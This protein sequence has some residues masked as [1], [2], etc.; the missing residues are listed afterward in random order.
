MVLKILN[1]L[2]IILEVLVIF[3]LLIIVHELGHF[4][5]AKW[6]GLVIEKFGIWFGKPIWKKTIGGVE[7]SL[8]SIPAGGFVALPQMAP[9]EVMEGKT[10][11]PREQLP[12]ASALDKIIVAFAGPLFS[13]GLAVLFAVIVWKAGR[14][15]SEAENTQVVGYVA[16]QSPAAEAGVLRGDKILSVDGFPVSRFSGLG[17]DSIIWRIVRSEGESIALRVEREKK[18]LTLLPKPRVPGKANWWNRKGL[19]QI[20]IGPAISS[21]VADVKLDS[22]AGQ[23]GLQIK[24]IITAVN[25]EKIY[26]PSDI[27]DYAAAHPDE[28][29][30]LTVQRGGSD[31]RLPFNPR[32]VK[33]NGVAKGSPAE[34]GGLKAGDII[35]GL[36]GKNFPVAEA[37]INY[38]S[39]KNNV[40]VKVQIQRGKTTEE[41]TVTPQVPTISP[42]SQKKPK[43]GAELAD[44]DGV[45]F[46]A[47]GKYDVRHPSPGE[48]I[49]ASVMSIVNT[50]DA[51]LSSKSSIGIQHM[52]GPVMMMNAY[53]T[54]LSGPEGLRMALWFSVVLNVN[55]ALI[56]LLPIPVL[57]GGHITLAIIEGIRRKPV[58]VRILEV[59]QTA[60]ALL[61]IGFMI[62][63]A[64]FDVQDL[65]FFGGH[66]PQVKFQQRA[67]QNGAEK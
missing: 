29:L 40:P 18:E 9:M 3:N 36:D 61:I 48:Q 52:G 4:L 35:L 39:D 64:F 46:S 8:G 25:G 21:V 22:P 20:G 56:N 53:Y 10:E 32:G 63:I 15:V 19:R 33:V 27:Y 26:G 43:I 6:R 31:I 47:M 14:P 1:I 2:F 11:T 38:I 12:S 59:V 41:L 60:C 50:L 13:F 44:D 28:P 24:D 5:A 51:I 62:F 17:S 16:E 54:M 49:H 34:A 67:Q 30:T 57:D 65:P 58:N 66:S 55:L 23:A 7:Y 37:L 42:D 45:R